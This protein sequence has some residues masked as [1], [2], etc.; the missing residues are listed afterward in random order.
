MR[1]LGATTVEVIDPVA[2][3]A[4][5]LRSLFDF[6]AIRALFASGFTMR[7]DAM[8]AV[9]GPC[10]K[11]ILEDELGASPGTV[12]NGEPLPGFGGG[13][14]DP[15]PVHARALVDLMKGPEAPDFADIRTRPGRDGPD[16]RT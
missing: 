4:G 9:A 10:T 1:S 2:I 3:H 13:H 5:V 12:L 15:N 11:A 6:A 8:H 14:P 7:F 16:V